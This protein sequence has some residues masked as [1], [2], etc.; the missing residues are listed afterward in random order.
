MPAATM[1]AWRT[2]FNAMK[3]KAQAAFNTASA[4]AKTFAGNARVFVSDSAARA[5]AAYKQYSQLRLNNSTDKLLAIRNN[6]NALSAKQATR[7]A[8]MNMA[9]HSWNPFVRLRGWVYSK[10]FDRTQDQ[11]D[12]LND[13]YSKEET[14]NN[15]LAS[16]FKDK[17]G[18]ELGFVGRMTSRGLAFTST[19]QTRAELKAQRK[20]ERDAMIEKTRNPDAYA[21][22]KSTLPGAQMFDKDGNFVASFNHYNSI[23]NT[24]EIDLATPVQKARFD[25]ARGLILTNVNKAELKLNANHEL[26]LSLPENRQFVNNPTFLSQVLKE[27]PEAYKTIPPEYFDKSRGGMLDRDQCLDFVRDGVLDKIAKAPTNAN[28]DKVIGVPARDANGANLGRNATHKEFAQQI[29]QDVIDKD[30][31]ILS[32]TQQMLNQTRTNEMIF[33][34][35]QAKMHASTTDIDEFFD[36]AK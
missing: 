17:F 26:D 31:E 11:I 5:G 35:Q 30:Q 27:H 7:S 18:E 23:D 1:S 4:Q 28:G 16:K 32:P 22:A 10:Q 20:Q 34:Q 36:H 13:R 9:R 33:R 8:Y 21:A 12:V 25:P 15:Y 14:K 3:T 6:L 2:K 29:F 24:I 19:M